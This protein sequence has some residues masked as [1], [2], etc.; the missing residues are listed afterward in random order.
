MCVTRINKNEIETSVHR[1][2]TNTNIYIN[3]YSHAPSNWKTGTLRNLIKRAK[4][5]SSTKLLLRNEI[6]YIRKVFTGNND[7]PLK[8]VN[9][10][11]DQ[12]LSQSLEVEAVETKNH[13]TKQNLQL[14]VPY[15]G[16][17]G[18]Q[19][20]SKMKKQLKRTLPDDIKTIIS[21]KSTKLSTKFPV[22]DKTDFQHKHNVVYYG[23][24]PDEGCKD[25]YVGE[26]KRRIVER[27]KDHNSKDNSSHLLKHARENGHTHVWK[28]DFKILGNNYQSN[29]KRK[30]SESLFIRQLK[31]SLNVNE[32]SVPLH[33]FN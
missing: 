10:I 27:I 8:V 31:P 15:S 6:D 18:H 7:Y 19:L 9:H 16:K 17:Q 29:F 33:L 13:D 1:K 11:I 25:N 5:I 24:C 21:Y 4:L 22:K 3:W 28:K 23:K 14:L 26:T 32:K 30:I 12:E 20:L 2:A